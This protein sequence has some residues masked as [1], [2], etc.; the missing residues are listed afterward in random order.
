MKSST[1]LETRAL[2][3]PFDPDLLRTLRQIGEDALAAWHRLNRDD[4]ST[5]RFLNPNTPKTDHVLRN[6]IVDGEL[7]L[8]CEA[9]SKAVNLYCVNHGLTLADTDQCLAS[10]NTLGSAV[11]QVIDRN[12]H[13]RSAVAEL[14]W[15]CH[16][17][18]PHD[19]AYDV[20]F[21]DPNIPFSIFVSVPEAKNRRS[22]LRVAENLVHETMHLQLSLFEQTCPLIDSAVPW[23]LY[24][25]WKGEE[26]PAQGILHGLYVF[27]VLRWMWRNVLTGSPDFDDQIFAQRRVEEIDEEIK[28]VRELDGAPALTEDGRKLV[29]Q[30]YAWF[31]SERPVTASAR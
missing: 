22:I 23:S 18:R 30:L 10:V 19:D 14:A 25:P 9:P 27:V 24:S 2:V 4:Y 13:L 20:S 29:A 21:S 11:S 8:R 26:R 16:L 17:V 5:E 6:I 12:Q 7:Q 28:A 31:D 1:S 15:R 3:P